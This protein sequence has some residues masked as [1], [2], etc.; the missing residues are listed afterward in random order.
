MRVFLDTNV[1]ASALAT[2]GLCADLLQAVA[3]EHVLIV[4]EPVIAELR[5]ILPRSFRLP[6]D[7]VDGYLAF[8]LD[9]GELAQEIL[10]PDT[11]VPDPDDLPI[12]GCA[13]GAAAD[14]FVTGD[15]PLL[16]L[17]EVQGMPL[18]SPR[19]LWEMWQSNT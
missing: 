2:R 3:K 6:D 13:L 16:E 4:G 5:R 11:P 19:G 1:L 7:I 10:P 17:S 18:V 12:L 9:I 8:L 15:K 14:V